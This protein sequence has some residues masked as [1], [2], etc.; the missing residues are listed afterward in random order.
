MP[1]LS[2]MGGGAGC[3]FPRGADHP[4][5]EQAHAQLRQAGRGPAHGVTHLKLHRPDGFEFEP[6]EFA[7]LRIPRVSH[8]GW[9]P[10]TISSNPEDRSHVGLH[11]RALGNWTR[12]LHRLFTRLPK[13]K[14]GNARPA[15]GALR[16]PQR[17]A[18]FLPPRGA[19]RGGI[20]VTPFASIL[21]S[22]VARAEQ[23]REMKLEKVHFFWLYRG[24]RPT[25]GSPGCWSRSTRCA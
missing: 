10:F 15:P 1:A 21:Q 24:R 9:H 8:F 4:Q 19:H 23:G 20:G 13:E 7:Y 22:I 3:R 2:P 18:V 17:A 5:G 12:R 14:R 11:I 25:N 6:G 16:K